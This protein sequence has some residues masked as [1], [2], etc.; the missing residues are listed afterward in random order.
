M[1]K[2][3]LITGVA[4]GIGRAVARKF[5]EE[6][7]YV[8]GVDRRPNTDSVVVNHFIQADIADVDASQQIFAQVTEQVGRLDSLVNNAAVQIVKPLVE[9]T[10]EEWDM[11]MSSNLRSVYLAVKNAHKLLRE[12]AGT[13]INVSSVH[14]IAT[15]AN[16]A[17]YAASKGALSA[18]T[19][20][21]A[22]ELTKDRIRVNAV[23]PGAVDTP[24]L[25][26]GLQRGHL[27]GKDDYELV[28]ALGMRHV[29]GRVGKPYEVAQAVWFLADDERSSFITG[30]ELIVDGGATIRL[31]T[32]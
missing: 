15:S 1:K 30:Q 14:A 8:I 11:V 16:I 22:I 17:A 32:E 13:I 20:A 3:V 2:V 9:T 25:R 23:L 18:L 28:K 5:H 31:S 21:L 7:W 19:R 10:H 29:I 26:A 6:N 27:S 24:M 12:S 4:G